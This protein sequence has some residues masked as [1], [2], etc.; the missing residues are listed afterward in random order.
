M[1]LLDGSA[2]IGEDGF[3]RAKQFIAD[4]AVACN[5]SNVGIVHCKCESRTT[6]PL[7]KFDDVLDLQDAIGDVDF[8]PS[9]TRV[10]YCIKHMQ[11]TTPWQDDVLRVVIVLTDGRIY[12]TY[13]GKH[14]E[15]VA[16]MAQAARDAGMELYAGAAGR[17]VLFD[18]T[19]LETIAGSMD[20]V[21]STIDEDPSWLTAIIS[22][23]HCSSCSVLA[24]AITNKVPYPWEDDTGP[25]E[26]S[27]V[28]E[29]RQLQQVCNALTTSG[30]AAEL[31][32]YHQAFWDSISALWNYTTDH[33]TSILYDV[34][35]RVEELLGRLEETIVNSYVTVRETTETAISE[36]R[37][38][39]SNII[40]A[41]T[42]IVPDLADI[43]DGILENIQDLI[44]SLIDKAG[45]LYG[46]VQDYFYNL[47]KDTFEPFRDF[48]N[49]VYNSLVSTVNGLLS[50]LPYYIESELEQILEE[51]NY[52][53]LFMYFDWVFG[54]GLDSLICRFLWWLIR[55]N[56]MPFTY[57]VPYEIP[58][59]PPLPPLPPPPTTPP[60]AP[61]PY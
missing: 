21:F 37:N 1:Y 58:G 31:Q 13:D 47:I 56:R 2:S 17:S 61:P 7:G 9:T 45:Q 36:V 14:T 24:K 27:C 60:V 57:P 26:G 28:F 29:P 33:L 50:S 34:N 6:V 46:V 48:V 35:T 54:G 59:I 25:N 8:I 3:E 5:D 52:I 20:R 11:C 32:L 22:V 38:A 4:V 19:G 40:D 43:V 30:C 42:N 12:G 18:Q 44:C 16:A 10:G 51:V 39:V 55:P 41:S 15:D 49:D 23:E 53:R